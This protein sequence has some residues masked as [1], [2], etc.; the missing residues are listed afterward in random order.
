MG[1]FG[2]KVLSAAELRSQVA[3]FDKA[4]ADI[5]AELEKV[6]ER[7]ARALATGADA[8]K[9]LREGAGLRVSLDSRPLAREA[10]LREVRRA[11][12]AEQAQAAQ[13]TQKTVAEWAK[14]MRG[15]GE[16]LRQ[17]VTALLA[18][19]ATWRTH[20][21][22]RPPEAGPAGDLS[23]MRPFFAALGLEQLGTALQAEIDGTPQVV[24]LLKGSPLAPG[25]ELVVQLAVNQIAGTAQDRLRVAVARLHD[26]DVQDPEV[27]SPEPVAAAGGA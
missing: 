12:R 24:K 15:D 26:G 7:V 22:A 25:A 5:A 10:L 9:A 19:L 20:A 21:A 4:T 8:S 23:T 6:Q 16:A 18:A 13:A 27:L 1:I 3:E 11:E 17:S 14:T 2:S